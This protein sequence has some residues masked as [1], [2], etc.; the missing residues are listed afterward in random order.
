ML[1]VSIF[2]DPEWRPVLEKQTELVT[3]M[4]LLGT[5]KGWGILEASGDYKR[6]ALHAY[7]QPM[8]GQA[9]YAHVTGVGSSSPGVVLPFRRD[10]NKVGRND[11]CPCGSSKKFKKCCGAE[12]LHW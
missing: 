6:A 3:P 11:P 12:T 1:G 2:L 10:E 7:F 4:V 8:R 5:E 9:A